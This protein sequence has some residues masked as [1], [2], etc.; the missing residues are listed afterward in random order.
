MGNTPSQREHY[1]IE[2]EDYE[3]LDSSKAPLQP[4]QN[5]MISEEHA[6]SI[7]DELTKLGDP[8]YQT[9]EEE[10]IK[11][12][13]FNTF[14]SLYEIITKHAKKA[15]EPKKS[16]KFLRQQFYRDDDQEG[17]KLVVLKSLSRENDAYT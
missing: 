16:E 7:K 9:K 1:Y 12:L 15:A 17:Y 11:W 4:K 6:E 5:S 10:N 8:I 2:E 13:K 14:H 3:A